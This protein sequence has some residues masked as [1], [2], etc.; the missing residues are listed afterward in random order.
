MQTFD[1]LRIG[2]PGNREGPQPLERRI[3]DIDDDDT[4]IV[5]TLAAKR[6]AK[7]Q[8][9][10]FDVLQ[11]SKSGPGISPDAGIGEEQNRRRRNRQRESEIQQP[12]R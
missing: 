10:Q 6:E 9:A 1:K 11:K 4:A 3:I 12:H 8:R 7:I 5:S 2:K